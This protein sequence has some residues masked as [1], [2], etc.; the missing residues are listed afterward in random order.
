MQKNSQILKNVGQGLL[1]MALMSLALLIFKPGLILA[2]PLFPLPDSS[3]YGDN[4]AT[5]TGATAQ[6]QF[7]S[8]TYGIIQNVRYIIGA[9]AILMIV[10]SGFRMA[11]GW[12]Q[13]DVYDQQRQSILYAGVGLVIVA[14]A[15]EMTN[16][17]QVACPEPGPAEER[18]GPGV[19]P[20]LQGI[21]GKLGPVGERICVCECPDRGGCVHAG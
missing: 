19:P 18:G 10:Y 13:E 4:I 6:A 21:S 16:I 15:G 11:T 7:A 5:P 1:I 17:F 2:Q 9:V 8:L 14:M 20:H 3:L 12:G